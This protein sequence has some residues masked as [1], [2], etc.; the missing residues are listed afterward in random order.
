MNLAAMMPRGDLTS[1]RYALADPGEEYLIYQPGSGGFA[2]SL[3]TGMYRYEWFNP[4]VGSVPVVRAQRYQAF[5]PP[6]SDHAVLYLK[7]I[8]PENAP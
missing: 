2:V 6:F 7:R 1:T 5:D 4:A 3:P 8:A